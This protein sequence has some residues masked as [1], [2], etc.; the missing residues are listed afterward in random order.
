MHL[1]FNIL[2]PD[3]IFAQQGG[4]ISMKTNLNALKKVRKS[5]FFQKSAVK[6]GMN[7]TNV[8]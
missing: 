3:A 5:E 4:V 8:N 2:H 7:K 1:L 6:L